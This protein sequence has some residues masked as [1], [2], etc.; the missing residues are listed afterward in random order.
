[1]QTATWETL[2]GSENLLILAPGP[3]DES[4]IFGGLI[5][6]S[7]RRGRPPFVVVLTDGSATNPGSNALN[8]DQLA[9]LHE[10]ETRA[11]A[12]HLGLPVNRLLMAGLLDGTLP[13][14]GPPFDAV[15]R[16][17]TLIM[18]ARDCN[19]ICA[20]GPDS[21]PAEAIAAHRI[22]AAV[23]VRS[24]V[25]LLWG[26]TCLSRRTYGWRLD[27]APELPAKR[28]AIAAH[29]ALQTIAEPTPHEAFIRP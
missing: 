7:C 2:T 23:A 16:G 25:G 24:G 19:V 17:L 18:W 10:R 1:M 14:E 28:A 22:A 9:N 6:R 11:A 15:V 26:L 5:A 8:P 21:A 27:I 13:A 12:R 4:L 29:A 3:G 20:P